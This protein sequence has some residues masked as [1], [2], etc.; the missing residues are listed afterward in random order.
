[1]DNALSAY[2]QPQ[3]IK[4]SAGEGNE[5]DRVQ[6]DRQSREIETLRKEIKLL[7]SADVPSQ[8]CVQW[9]CFRADNR[10]LK[11][12]QQTLGNRGRQLRRTQPKRKFRK[13]FCQK[14]SA[15]V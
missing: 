8:M 14:F 9:A 7:E 11:Q 2:R 15:L 4:R 6:A 3:D 5:K 13:L 12:E 10:R 1:M